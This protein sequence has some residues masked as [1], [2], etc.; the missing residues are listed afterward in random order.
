M[1][2][3]DRYYAPVLPRDRN[4]KILEIG[5]GA[6]EFLAWLSGRGYADV[7]GVDIDPLAVEAAQVRFGNRVKRITDLAEF[8]GQSPAT[9]DAIVAADS[10][11]YLNEKELGEVLSRC[12]LALKPEGVF[13]AV[14]LN[15]AAVSAYYTVSK[16]PKIRC[17]LSEAAVR[18]MWPGADLEVVDVVPERRP[19][20][21]PISALHRIAS[22]WVSA[23]L[24]LV[25]FA[26]RGID[27]ENP[28]YFDKSLVVIAR[29]R[30]KT[31]A[32]RSQ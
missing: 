29:K 12:S 10:L 16:D 1:I 26:E 3:F 21:G 31:S 22:V 4:A 14:I 15:A 2:D 7:V 32:G 8:L 30:Q 27:S 9:W 28:R 23:F 25:Y 13:V 20:S 24:R 18:R 17:T 11:Y 5:F 6:G 19:I